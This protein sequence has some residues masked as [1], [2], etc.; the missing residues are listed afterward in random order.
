MAEHAAQLEFAPNKA[1]KHKKPDKIF[2]KIISGKIYG[3]NESS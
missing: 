1:N 3:N 2:F